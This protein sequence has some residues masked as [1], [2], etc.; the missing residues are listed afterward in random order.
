[1]KAGAFANTI[2]SH[3]VTERA[4]QAPDPTDMGNTSP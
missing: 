3:G 4:A 1:M 2:N